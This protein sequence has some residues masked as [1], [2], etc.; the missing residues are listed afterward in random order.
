MTLE[1]TTF[2]TQQIPD[3]W[4][5]GSPEVRIDRDEILVIGSLPSGVAPVPFREATREMRMQIAATAEAR[6]LRKVSWAVR[7]GS[8][9]HRFSSLAVPVMS[10]L[11][12]EERLVLD[13]LIEG[14]LARTRSEALA[15][16]VRLV[17][18]HQREWL[19]ELRAAAA[20]VER[21]RAKGPDLSAS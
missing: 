20:A 14:G 17:G 18:R 1:I 2:F 12:V 15:W 3:A 9:E 19:D 7:V 16:C 4:F 6:W 11:R 8:T 13:A 5:D 10:R 21:I